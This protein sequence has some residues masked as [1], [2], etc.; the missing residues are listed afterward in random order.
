MAIAL[1]HSA[2]LIITRFLA[3]FVPMPIAH[4]SDPVSAAS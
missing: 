1:P 3:L 4:H 2:P